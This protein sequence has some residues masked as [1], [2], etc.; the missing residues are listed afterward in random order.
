M[1]LR[2][3]VRCVAMLGL[4]ITGAGSCSAG[5]LF[6]VPATQS[7]ILY[8]NNEQLGRITST[9]LTVTKG[10]AISQGQGIY[11]MD[12]TASCSFLVP[13]SGNWNGSVVRITS[14]GGGCKVGYLLTM[15]GTATGEYG[16]SESISGT[17]RIT[18]SGAWTG[19]ESGTWR[20]GLSH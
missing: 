10:G 16:K 4:L 1:D 12:V 18:Y 2:R 17:Y 7:W 5:D 19:G 6:G 20:A 11:T 3:V 14:I 8:D 9:Y 15:E 13:L